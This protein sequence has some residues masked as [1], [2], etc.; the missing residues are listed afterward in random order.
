MVYLPC[1]DIADCFWFSNVVK[2]TGFVPME[3]LWEWMVCKNLARSFSKETLK[4]KLK[5]Q[6]THSDNCFFGCI[7][8]ILVK[9]PQSFLFIASGFVLN[10]TSN[11]LFF[12]AFV[13]SRLKVW[14]P[15]IPLKNRRSDAEIRDFRRGKERIPPVKKG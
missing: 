12:A 6:V 9:N 5:I 13:S 15:E 11:Q 1:V 10:E 14:S 3:I 4:P 2:Y 7:L 8:G